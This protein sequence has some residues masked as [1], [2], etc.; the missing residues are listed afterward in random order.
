MN[1][2]TIHIL[3]VHTL[4]MFHWVRC[5]KEMAWLWEAEYSTPRIRQAVFPGSCSRESPTCKV[6]ETREVHVGFLRDVVRLNVC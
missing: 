1:S 6:Q 3:L 2:A 4:E 5:R